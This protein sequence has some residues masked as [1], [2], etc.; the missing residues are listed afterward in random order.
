MGMIKHGAGEIIQSSETPFRKTI[1][2][3]CGCSIQY[4]DGDPVPDLCDK[5]SRLEE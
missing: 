2:K 5:C 1:C 3:K 4:G